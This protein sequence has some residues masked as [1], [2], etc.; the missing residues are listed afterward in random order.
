M[1]RVFI[2]NKPLRD[3][4]LFFNYE[5]ARSHARKLLRRKAAAGK[6]F[7][8]LIDSCW[9]YYSNPSINDYGYSVRRV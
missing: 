2:H 8:A 6:V 1:Y 7:P 3:Q 5:A 4:P 9:T